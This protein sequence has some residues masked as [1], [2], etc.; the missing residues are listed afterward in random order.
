MTQTWRPSTLPWRVITP[1]A[2]VPSASNSPPRTG[3][4]CA[5]SPS[6]TKLSLSNRRPRRSRPVSLP[7]YFCLAIFSGPPIPR[8]FLR[9]ALSSATSAENSSPTMAM[10]MWACCCTLCRIPL[11]PPHEREGFQ[12]QSELFSKSNLDGPDRDLPQALLNT[13]TGDGADFSGP[14]SPKPLRYAVQVDASRAFEP[15]TV[16]VGRGC[17][18]LTLERS[19]HLRDSRRAHNSDLDAEPPVRSQFAR[20]LDNRVAPPAKPHQQ[21]L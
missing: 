15:D 3:W 14:H 12:P 16:R 11:G 13:I 21:D 18:E 1:S 2:G 8:F 6:S 5:S 9:R 20:Y 4:W 17:Q 19:N 7:R 10:S